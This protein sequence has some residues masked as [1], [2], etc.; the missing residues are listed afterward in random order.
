[1]RGVGCP[2]TTAIEPVS[3]KS[4]LLG[5][6]SIA[7]PS[8]DLP[9]LTTVSVSSGSSLLSLCMKLLVLP[10]SVSPSPCQ[11]KQ[12]V[13]LNPPFNPRSL[14]YLWHED[15]APDRLHHPH[16]A[17]QTRAS[18]LNL[19][20]LDLSSS[21]HILDQRPFLLQTQGLEDHTFD[22]VCAAPLAPIAGVEC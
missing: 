21:T 3:K 4:P 19:L 10:T 7:E 20:S 6:C 22:D 11:L 15:P 14:T 9:L 16:L 12:L 2:S 13:S 18:N 8:A 1:M 17:Q 5:S